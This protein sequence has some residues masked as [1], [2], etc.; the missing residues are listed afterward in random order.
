MNI[1]DVLKRQSLVGF[2][3]KPSKRGRGPAKGSFRPDRAQSAVA[4]ALLV[5]MVSTQPSA[6]HRRNSAEILRA[7]YKEWG[8]Q[9]PSPTIIRQYVKSAREM[10]RH[11]E[12]IGIRIYFK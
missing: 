4:V 12:K 8:Y 9:E 5:R 6:L 10:I 11:L 2:S 1:L 3:A 7:L